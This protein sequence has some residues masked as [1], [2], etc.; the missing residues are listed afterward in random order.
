MGAVLR[1]ENIVKKF[2]GV[3]ALDKVNLSV[4]AGDVLAL[5]GENGAGKSTLIKVISG[6]YQPDEGQIYLHDQKIDKMSPKRAI[7]LGIAVIYQELSYMPYMT[8][9]ENIFLGNLPMK[10][11]MVDYK[12]LKTNSLEVQKKVGLGNLDP[13]TIV[14]K[15]STSQKQLL[16]I[17]RAIA[18]NAQIIIFDEPTSALNEHET[19]I[20][21]NLIRKM[22]QAGKSIIYISHKLDE[23][24]EISNKIQIMRDGVQVF[25]GNLSELNRDQIISYMVGREIK[26]MYPIGS[27][28]LGNNLLTV[29]H[30]KNDVVKDVSITVKEKEIVGLYGLMGSGG[31]ELLESLFGYRKY[32]SQRFEIEGKLVSIASP[33]DAINSGIAY[34]PG[35]R[36]TEGLMLNQSVL[37]NELVVTLSKYKKGGLLNW[38]KMTDAANSWIQTLNIRTPSAKTPVSSLSGGNQQKVILAKWLNN[39]PKLFLLNEPTKGIDVGAKV[40]I[41]KQME[42]ICESGS[43]ILLVTTDLPELLAIC[44]RVYVLFDGTVGKELGK[45]ELT[46]ENVVKY[47]V[48]DN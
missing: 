44:D 6:A 28:K 20:L 8:I 11:K 14:A 16:E 19:E 39:D 30:L 2:P 37:A 23:I 42:K 48:G 24:F 22:Q 13:F 26:D 40:E 9:A 31:P 35:E 45:S 5:V 46:Q 3:T 33:I 29:E 27:R 17:A 1:L 4:D 32:Q 38:K 36:K 34:T 47:A 21:F 41:Y 7:E 43:S 15:L 12:T 10:R 25:F 18:R